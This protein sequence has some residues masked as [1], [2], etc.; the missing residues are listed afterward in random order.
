[1]YTDFRLATR[2]TWKFTYKGSELLDGAKFKLHSVSLNEQSARETLIKLVSDPAV[3]ANDKRVQDAKSEIETT[4][5]IRE[6]LIVFVH[7]FARNG[8]QV[9]HLSIGDV[10]F[11]CLVETKLEV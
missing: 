4:A 5:E 2:D 9:Y 11:F 1:M 8:D 6:K 10:V 3:S 7:E